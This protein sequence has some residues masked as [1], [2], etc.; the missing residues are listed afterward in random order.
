MERVKKLRFEHNGSY[1]TVPT[2]SAGVAVY[3]DGEQIESFLQR[4]DQALYQAK[5]HGRNRI[6]VANV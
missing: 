6:E 4:A 5:S 3:R 1:I 2:F